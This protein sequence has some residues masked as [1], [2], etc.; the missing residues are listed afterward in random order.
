[1]PL[2]SLDGVCRTYWRGRHE[3]VALDR[4]SFEL[5]QGEFAA[6]FG[7]R[8]A[9]K[10]TLLRIAAGLEAPDSGTVALSGRELFPGGRRPRLGGLPR[11]IG[12]MQRSEPLIASMT[13]LDYVGMPLLEEVSHREAQ[14]RAARALDRMAVGHLA[15]AAWGGMSDAERML[16]MLARAVV[17]EPVLLLADDPTAGLDTREREVVLGL[18]R[19]VTETSGVTALITVPDVPDLLR[20]H[21]VMSLSAGELMQPTRHDRGA[22]IDFPRSRNESA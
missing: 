2:L 21:R 8:A 22:V 15:D 6:I 10:S 5:E 3:I 19:R 14:Q 1:M 12:W 18:L 16:T 13:M 11:G 20:S 4:V 7:Q 17:R 9:G